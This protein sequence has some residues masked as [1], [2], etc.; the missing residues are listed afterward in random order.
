MTVSQLFQDVCQPLCLWDLSLEIMYLCRFND[1]NLVNKLWKSI[2]YRLLPLRSNHAI[3]DAFLKSKRSSQ[4]FDIDSNANLSNKALLETYHL[5]YSS[6]KDTSF[7]KHELWRNDL[8]NTLVA[9]GRNLEYRRQLTSS[10]STLG[11]Y[12]SVSTEFIP[13]GYLLEEIEEISSMLMQIHN[14]LPRDWFIN[15]LRDM[16]FDEISVAASS[17]IAIVKVNIILIEG[18][19]SLVEKWMG[20]S[21]DKLVQLI[22][23]LTYILKYWIHLYV[24]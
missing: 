22:S 18:Y 14:P 3:A 23:N 16:V 24:E 8:A 6:N 2:L 10:K 21:S 5:Q 12:S 15:C 17:D 9:V 7:E 19:F 13:V 4:T 1:Q 20:K 11:V